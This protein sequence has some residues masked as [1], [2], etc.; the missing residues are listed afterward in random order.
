MKPLWSMSAAKALLLS[1]FAATAVTQAVPAN[2]DILSPQ[3]NAPQSGQLLN[4]GASKALTAISHLKTNSSA[5]SP[6]SCGVQFSAW[7]PANTTRT[8]YTYGW[9][10]T[11]TIYWS[12]MD[13]SYPSS[14]YITL[15]NVSLDRPSSNTVAYL[16]TVQ[17][18]SPNYGKLFEGRFC[19]LQ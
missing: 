10:P 3:A 7:I 2:A 13:D 19:Y 14:G 12:I 9:N 17:N 1:A 4:A 18:L 8:Y 5:V 15:S 11:N 16:L 6:L